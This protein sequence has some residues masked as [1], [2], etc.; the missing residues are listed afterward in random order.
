MPSLRDCSTINSRSVGALRLNYREMP[1]PR[2]AGHQQAYNI[3]DAW[4][5]TS[6]S[7]RGKPTTQLLAIFYANCFTDGALVN[8]FKFDFVLKNT[9]SPNIP[10]VINKR[11][12]PP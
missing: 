7:K 8:S 12:K 3:R 11:K 1:K 9:H 2:H 6:D 4:F 5:A 10:T